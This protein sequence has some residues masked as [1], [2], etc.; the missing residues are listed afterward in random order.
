MRCGFRA[1]LAGRCREGDGVPFP[2]GHKRVGALP[3]GVLSGVF[4]VMSTLSEV[5]A[6]KEGRSDVLSEGAGL[7]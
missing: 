5:F 7:L 4:A 6:L 3:T 2:S 1:A